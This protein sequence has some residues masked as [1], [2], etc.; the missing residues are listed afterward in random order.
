MKEA[1]SRLKET[2][3]A[4]NHQY[5][6]SVK[7][8]AEVETADLKVNELQQFLKDGEAFHGIVYKAEIKKLTKTIEDMNL[9][10]PHHIE[11]KEG[12]EGS[13]EAEGSSLDVALVPPMDMDTLLANEWKKKLKVHFK[14][15]LRR[16][17]LATR[18]RWNDRGS[19]YFLAHRGRGGWRKRL[20]HKEDQDRT[21]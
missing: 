21:N 6:Y 16:W 17:K 2:K 14:A 20:K 5:Q 10:T 18:N 4:L 15:S 8:C 9:Q 7:L 11:K 19:R 12:V 3:D 13:K 1:L